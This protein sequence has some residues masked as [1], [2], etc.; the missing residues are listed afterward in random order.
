MSAFKKYSLYYI[1]ALLLIAVSLDVAASEKKLAPLLIPGTT[2]I[3]A[4]EVFKIAEKFDDLV[5]IDAR[6]RSDRSQGYI[7]GSISLPDVETNCDTLAKVIP[8]KSTPVLF[9][10]NG[11]KCGR[12][13]ISSRIAIKC[14]YKNIYWFRGGFEVWKEKKLPYI[15]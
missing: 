14:G 5:I 15:K 2:K 10:C 7:Q 4:E 3:T 12:S 8:K 6:I 9:Y 11:I 1:C 13:V